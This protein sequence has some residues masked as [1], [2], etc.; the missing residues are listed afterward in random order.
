[1]ILHAAVSNDGPSALPAAAVS[2]HR[3]DDGTLI[4]QAPLPTLGAGATLPAE[5]AW[6]VAD[7]PAGV[8]TVTLTLD[9]LGTAIAGGAAL[10]RTATVALLPDLAVGPGD[11]SFAVSS[12]H[13]ATASLRVHNLGLRP[14][15]N[16]PLVLYS[17][18]PAT[19]GK[20]WIRGTLSWIAPGSSADFS[21]DWTMPPG[22]SPVY[23]VVDPQGTV[24]E[25]DRSNNVALKARDRLPPINRA[26]LPLVLKPAQPGTTIRPTSTPGPTRTATATR[27]LTPTRTPTRT[28]S[29]TPSATGTRT[30]TATP[31]LSASATPSPTGTASPTRTGTPTSPP[32]I[33]ATPTAT[34]TSTPTRTA[35]PTSTSTAT[36]TPTATGTSTPT[37]TATPT[38]TSTATATP[39]SADTSTPTRT[40]TPTSTSTATATPT[41]A[42]TSTPT[43]TATPTATSTAV[44]QCAWRDD[45]ASPVLNPS[46]SWVRGDPSHWSLTARPG[47]LRITTQTGDLWT[48]SNDARNL[49]LLNAPTGDFEISTR[50][51]IQPTQNY[52]Q[53]DL[54]VWADD[55]NYVKLGR[56]Y[57]GSPL[58][59]FDGEIGGAFF[60]QVAST[61]LNATY[62]KITR[63]GT[64]YRGYFSADGQTWQTVGQYAV[65]GLTAVRVGVGAW[66]GGVSAPEIPADF[67]WFC[68]N[69][70]VPASTATPTRTPT[71]TPTPTVT[72]TSTGSPGWQV[73]FSDGFEGSF[74]GAWHRLGNPGWGRTTCKSAAGNYSIW[75]A[76]DGTGA[77]APCVS[78][79][80]SNLNAWLIYG[81][82]SLADATAAE[83][84]FQRW[85]RTEPD[86]DM[87]WWLASVDGTNFVGWQ[88]SGDSEGWKS[89][90]FDLVDFVHAPEVWLAFAFT[91][92][93]S[94]TDVGAFVDEVVIRKL[95]G[96]QATG[97]S[98]SQP[99]SR[100]DLKPASAVRP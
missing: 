28:P 86:K 24:A 56:S 89:V 63:T 11:I 52:Q 2:F 69:G 41:V 48:S 23:L 55:D 30:P 36:A 68:L 38:S 83:A 51:E 18:A 77:A 45:F 26:Y 46:W 15:E 64:T 95:T 50:V 39:I 20:P 53:A 61:T 22:K 62:L 71:A 65:A 54:L 10:A 58:I 1:M 44:V 75:P 33:T 29:M 93:G 13:R 100:H 8:Y 32:T 17:G 88:S 91:S 59:E 47:Y 80:P 40:A 37:R 97:R 92:D 9:P 60:S 90:T 94:G 78:N 99:P 72:P 57:S 27:T 19:G 98:D 66:N 67:D 79:Y 76:A 34:G 35:T 85:E 16:V 70:G 5:V 3:A 96:T 4:G 81:P 12:D 7:L 82:F 73:I 74:P 14:A 43:G 87:F 6:N 31:N 49:L 84:T 25:S 21:A 42:G